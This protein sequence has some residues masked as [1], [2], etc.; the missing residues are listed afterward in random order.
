MGTQRAI[1]LQ[2]PISLPS[3]ASVSDKEWFK[4]YPNQSEGEQHQLGIWSRTERQ[5]FP[6]LGIGEMRWKE[7]FCSA[8]P[9]LTGPHPYL[10][11]VLKRSCTWKWRVHLHL[12][13]RFVQVH[14]F[15]KRVA[16]TCLRK[17]YF[18]IEH[19]ERTFEK[20]VKTKYTSQRSWMGANLN[21]PVKCPCPC[22]EKSI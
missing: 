18:Y 4:R 19:S 2:L 13:A 3:S 20:T 15:F 12:T 7:A 16:Y 21:C 5:R 8:V 10:V 22:F 6:I 17:L 14:T 9:S 1:S 11:K